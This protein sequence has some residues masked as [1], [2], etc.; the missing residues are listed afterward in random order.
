[1]KDAFGSVQSVLVLGGASEIALATVLRLARSR[2]RSVVLAGRDMARMQEAADSLRTAGVER[3]EVMPFDALRTEEHQRFV[4]EVWSRHG[5]IDLV[6]LAFGVL[7][8][9]QRDESDAASA[10]QVMDVNFRGAVSVGIPIAQK[11]REQGHGNIVVLSSV[12]GERVR[13]DNFVY[14]A[15]K[16]GL[17]GFYQGLAD[18]LVGSGVHVMVVRPGFV[19]TRMT[20]GRPPAPFSTTPEKVAEDIA[21]GLSRNAVT[22]WSP[23][24]L[25]PVMSAVRHLPRPVFRRL[26]G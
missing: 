9:Q 1:M 4:D 14:G 12:A 7:G 15:S 21:R 5:E 3:V 18:A 16:A 25:R 23:A 24:M 2:A 26:R 22:V 10:L 8:D 11:L 6:L 13:R 19:H 17:D 20:E